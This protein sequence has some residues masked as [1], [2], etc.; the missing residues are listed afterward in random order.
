MTIAF[1]YNAI[2]TRHEVSIKP[3]LQRNKHITQ[4]KELQV[5]QNKL[6]I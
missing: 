4:N 5:W 1:S 2:L 3:Y 6:K